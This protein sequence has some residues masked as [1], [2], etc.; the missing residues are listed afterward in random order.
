VWS[1]DWGSAWYRLHQALTLKCQ[2][3]GPDSSP[4]LLETAS[5][6][7]R[8]QRQ[9]QEV[10]WYLPR[11]KS[12][13]MAWVPWPFPPSTLFSSQGHTPPRK[14]PPADTHHPHAVTAMGLI[15]GLGGAA[16]PWGS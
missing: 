4:G 13:K 2:G 11:I 10:L 16:I 9:N 12:G 7:Y 1:W 3:H 14:K 6:S 5:W 15:A 8:E